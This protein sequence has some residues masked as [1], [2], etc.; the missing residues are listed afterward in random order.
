MK[1]PFNI[2]TMFLIAVTCCVVAGSVYVYAL[3]VPHHG[4]DVDPSDVAACMGC[5]DGTIGKAVAFCTVGCNSSKAHV[6]NKHY[7]PAGKSREFNSITSVRARGVVL[8]NDQVVCISCHD[9]AG[10]HEHHLVTDNKG[11]DLCLVCHIK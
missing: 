3:G 1:A 6:I 11:S 9:I 7:P 8:V 5:H 10:Q 4:L 2:R